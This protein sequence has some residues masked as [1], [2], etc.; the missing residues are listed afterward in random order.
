MIPTAPDAVVVSHV[1][2]VTLSRPLPAPAA[3]L[4]PSCPLL[5]AMANTWSPSV[6]FSH[7][8]AKR[9]PYRTIE[10]LCLE[11]HPTTLS[12]GL[13]DLTTG[14]RLVMPATTAAVSV[15]SIGETFFR[16]AAFV[17]V[18]TLHA[19]PKSSRPALS[20]PPVVASL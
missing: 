5:A 12:D 3:V 9:R 20:S 10:A 14:N 2:P 8:I 13:A 6:T 18:P 15:V 16:P 17:P 7:G 4:P 1:A 11:G 19:T